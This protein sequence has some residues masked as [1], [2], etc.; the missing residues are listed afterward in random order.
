MI[1]HGVARPRQ[2]DCLEWQGSAGGGVVVVIECS[3]TS[4]GVRGLWVGLGTGERLGA[5]G[6]A[7]DTSGSGDNGGD[8][9]RPAAA[10]GRDD[11]RHRRDGR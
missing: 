7:S 5:D 9:G 10:G 6:G 11:G 2:N 3:P 4:L 1:F 8:D